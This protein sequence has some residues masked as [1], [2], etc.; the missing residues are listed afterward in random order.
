MSPSAKNNLIGAIAIITGFAAAMGFS[1]FA[2][3]YS[4]VL[5]NNDSLMRA[6]RCMVAFF[7]IL[8]MRHLLDV[9]VP[10]I[11]IMSY[12]KWR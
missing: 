7:A 3:Q 11:R 4:P 2:P 9:Y 5:A 10:R 6:W 8:L 12:T 1:L